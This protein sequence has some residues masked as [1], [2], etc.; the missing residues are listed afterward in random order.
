MLPFENLWNPSAIK[1]QIGGI[2][3]NAHPNWPTVAIT[4]CKRPPGDTLTTPQEVDTQIRGNTIQPGRKI[5]VVMQAIPR[6]MGAH[7]DLLR[8]I[9]GILS[10]S[11]QPVD[12]GIDR[13][14]ESLIQGSEIKR[15]SITRKRGRCLSMLNIAC[16][17]HCHAST[18]SFLITRSKDTTFTVQSLH[19]ITL[20]KSNVFLAGQAGGRYILEARVTGN[21]G[22]VQT[23]HKQG[24]V[25]NRATGYHIVMVDV[26]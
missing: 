8:D 23:S 5:V 2:L 24:T 18:C 20:C 9:V 15:M 10:A 1:G 3:F 21:S 19:I 12:V 4:L 16:F 25:P 11:E 7:R 26:A 6:D 13:P 17:F 22:E 14:L